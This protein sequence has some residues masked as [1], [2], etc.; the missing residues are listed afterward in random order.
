MTEPSRRS[1]G[2]T[3][4]SGRAPRER[5][6]NVTVKE[7]KTHLLEVPLGKERF[8]SSQAEFPLRTSFLVEVIAED[9]R[10]GW[11]EGGQWGP[12]G[13]PAAIVDQVLAPRIIGRSVHEVVPIWEELYAYTRDYGR[14]GPYL[15]AQSAID[16]ALWDLKGQDL[17]VPVHTLLGGAFRDRVRAYATGCYYRGED[18]LDVDA[19]VHAL[20]REATS[21]VEAGFSILK[22][23]IGLLP[24]EQDARRVR[25]VRKAIGPEVGLLCDANHAYRASDAVRMGR[26][27]EE[28]GVLFFEEP[29]PPE[30][31]DGYRHVRE[32]LDIAISGGECEHT[33]WGFRNLLRGGYVDIAQPDIAVVGGLSEFQKVL[34]L[35]T[36]YNT[37]VL[38][39]VWGS[40]V[41]LAAALQALAIIPQ[42]PYRAFP[43]AYE[44]APIVEFDRNPNPLRDDLLEKPFELSDGD[45]AIPQGPGLGIQVNREAVSRYEVRAG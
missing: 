30:D 33:R 44:T 42:T 25:A 19:A 31:L 1:T 15:E 11:G 41:A 37:L 17:G 28:E 45:L 2:R 20:S 18:V 13:P 23:K 38:P 36:A 10:T 3:S 5:T 8:Y 16:V 26:I 21:Y 27:L 14:N 43:I 6:H 4:S 7:I 24:V 40:G 32:S 34:A 35:A 22:I 39:H 29:V 9:G 12:S